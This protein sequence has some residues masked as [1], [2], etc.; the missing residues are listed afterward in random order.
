MK[1]YPLPQKQTRILIDE[2]SCKGC[3]LCLQ[4]CPRK[5]FSAGKKRNRAGYQIPEVTEAN[6]CTQCL[7]CELTCP[8]LALTV[9][10][11]EA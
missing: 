9:E 3:S 11:K 4:V 2:E 1:L 10:K 6:N 8:D 7:L 5:V